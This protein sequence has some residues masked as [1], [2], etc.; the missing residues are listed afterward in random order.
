MGGG[1]NKYFLRLLLLSLLSNYAKASPKD[2]I[3]SAKYAESAPLKHDKNITKET[4]YIG[5]GA[6][7][8]VLRKGYNE[9]LEAL[10][11]L[12]IDYQLVVFGANNNSKSSN[13][14]HFLGR[15]NDDETL[16][17]AY[18]SCDIFVVPSLAEN[19]SNAIMEALS[20]GI[21]VIAFDIGGN[22][23][24][25]AHK[26]NGYLAK[27]VKDLAKGIEW[28]LDSANYTALSINA[29]NGVLAK[30]EAKKVAQ[31][32]ISQYQKMLNGGGITSLDSPESTL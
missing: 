9:L 11:L 18:N 27:D 4:Y 16:R 32:Y 8:N 22:G 19:L 6:I 1:Q 28:S 17:L 13:N 23:D 29:R 30:F 3:D 10:K 26:I 7:D 24:M 20:C 31:K 2:F 5:F 12:T 25:I 14:T 15:L 21:P